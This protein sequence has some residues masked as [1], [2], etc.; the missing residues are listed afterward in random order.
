MKIGHERKHDY[1]CHRL[2][3]CNIFLACEP[4]AG[5]RTVKITENKCKVDWAE[6]AKEIADIHFPDAIKIFLVMDNLGTHTPGALNERYEP[7]EAKSILDKFE[8]VYT[9]NMVVG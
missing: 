1:E 8:F 7:S 2:G 9:P 6:F 4:L 5:F 3:V